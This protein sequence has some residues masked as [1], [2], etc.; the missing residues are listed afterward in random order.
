MKKF[1]I[2]TAIGYINAPPHIGHALEYVQTDVLARYHRL[3]G[4]RVFFLTGTDEHGSKALTTAKKE[5]KSPQKLADENAEKFRKLDQVLEISYDFFIRTTDQ[6][7]HWPGVVKLWKKLEEKGDIY[8]AKYKGFYCVGC[9]EFKVK[10]DLID[11]KCPIHEE[12]VE[13]LEEE[14][15]FFRLLKYKDKVKEIIETDRLKI[16]PKS[17]KK[18]ILNII[19]EESQDLSFSRPTK[20]LPWG[21]PVPRDKSH[22]IYVWGDALANYLTGAG[23]GWDEKKFSD[24][25]PADIHLI[26]KDILRFHAFY[27]PAMLLSARL[28]LPET[29][30]VHGFV[31]SSGKKM[32]KSLGNVID[33]FGLIEKF[34][35]DALRYFL[36]KEIPPSDDGDITTAQFENIYNGDLANGLGNLTSRVS[37]LCEKSKLSFVSPK[38]KTSQAQLFRKNKI[39]HFLEEFSFNDALRFIWQRIS[40]VDKKIN[41]EKPWE[42]LEGKH[43]E[44]KVKK[45]LQDL[46]DDVREIAS[47]LGPFLPQ[48][49]IAIQKQFM[50]PKIKQGKALFPRLR[51]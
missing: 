11:G 34:G 13:V 18:E 14:N 26:G 21:I 7:I 6:K 36:L 12:K 5:G 47:Y 39:S 31:T 37:A 30:F 23:F 27:W 8:K 16:I 19:A 10:K 51:G 38:I 35:P 32:S 48:T 50:G 28:P 40:E 9:E 24:L 45:V 44:E 41:E 33:P 42:H 22:I 17:R 25:W 49:A 29:I 20:K 3:L 15:Y 43:D 2:T 4:E 1:F 46:V